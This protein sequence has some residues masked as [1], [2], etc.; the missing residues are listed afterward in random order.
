MSKLPK[1]DNY[2][3]LWPHEVPIT[4]WSP[5]FTQGCANRMVTS[6]FKYGDVA[7]AYP[8]K[9]DAIK[10]LYLRLDKYLQTGNTE[11]LMD[12]ANF[13]MIEFKHPKLEG[14]AYRPTEH[15]GPGRVWK[16][17]VDPNQLPNDVRKHTK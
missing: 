11:F 4:E 9:V 13:A 2:P 6:W 7:T 12:V 1:Y 16:G 14:A 8:D 5:E 3:V 17:E 10:S 15:G